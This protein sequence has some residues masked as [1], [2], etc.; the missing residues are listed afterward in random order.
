MKEKPDI[1]VVYT[2]KRFGPQIEYVFGTILS[3]LG[4]KYEIGL[5]SG[6]NNDFAGP[7]TLVISYSHE[8]PKIIAQRQIHIYE[9]SLF[10]DQYLSRDSLPKVPLL[11]F[12][13]LPII[14][15]GDK[16]V[17]GH[18]RHEGNFIETD[19]DII[20]SS[21]FMLTRYEEVIVDERDKFDR[22]P[23]TASL[24]YKE[25][26]LDRPIVNEYIELLWTWIDSFQLGFRRRER[27]GGKRFAVCLTHDVDRVRKFKIYPPLLTIKRLAAERKDFG[28]ILKVSSDWARCLM[29]K[30][31]DPYNSFDYLIHLEASHGTK[32]TYFF[33]AG[34]SCRYDGEYTIKDLKI[35]NLVKKLDKFGF[36]IGLHASFQSFDDDRLLKREKEGLEELIGKE[37]VSSRQH[38]LR[39]KTPNT[40]RVLENAGIQYD[41]TLC[42][43][44][45][46]GFRC[47]FCLPYRPFDLHENRVMDIYELPLI[48][49]DGSLYAY[50]N[51]SAEEGLQRTK[52]MIKAVKGCGGVFTL[53]WHNSSFY[54]LDYPAWPQIYRDILNY[55][56]GQDVFCGVVKG[57]CEQWRITSTS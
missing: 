27:W 15:Q 32:S 14:Y 5:L 35:A 31:V 43:P 2:N 33:L 6:L 51:L 40:W 25:G 3:V 20:A 1:Y 34:R 47:G 56:D 16:T 7:K 45:V 12:N 42:F 24:A 57:I 28:G 50:E 29:G 22:F 23:A 46:E 17:E 10:T 55:I 13:D 49:M 19:I 38:Y 53:L 9:S 39:W 30:K 36:E 18:V 4:L 54:E 44:E 52:K 48:V 21:F 41:A 26:F 37:I 11:R 8:R